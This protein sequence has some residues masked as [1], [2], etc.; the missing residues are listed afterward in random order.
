MTFP[1]LKE[2]SIFTETALFVCASQTVV[3]L[4]L[5]AG[6]VWN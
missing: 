1:F 4:A 5:K 3:E 2:V 6:V